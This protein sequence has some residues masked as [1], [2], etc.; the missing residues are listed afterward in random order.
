MT[1][2]K[3]LIV[4]FALMFALIPTDWYFEPPSDLWEDEEDGDE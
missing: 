3:V 2:L 4:T 1:F